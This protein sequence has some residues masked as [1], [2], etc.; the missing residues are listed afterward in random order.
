M[1]YTF[2]FF[3]L[4]ALCPFLMVMIVA[5]MHRVYRDYRLGQQVDGAYSCACRS[6]KCDKC[7]RCEHWNSCFEC[8]HLSGFRCK[9]YAQ[10]DNPNKEKFPTPREYGGLMAKQAFEGSELA[11]DV[12]DVHISD[13][14]SGGMAD[15]D[16]P[17]CKKII[18]EADIMA[19]AA[20]NLAKE[21]DEKFYQD[22]L[23]GNIKPSPAPPI[24]DEGWQDDLGCFAGRES[25]PQ[26]PKKKP[27]KSKKKSKSKKKPAKRKTIKGHRVWK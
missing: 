17:T 11:Q 24:S 26:K 8:E 23:A 1:M 25:L 9:R 6:G 22:V 14:L 7:F 20:R 5:E 4:I 15:A 21:E 18:A 12:M 2:L 13:L 27:T 3:S 19:Q 10:V 16:D